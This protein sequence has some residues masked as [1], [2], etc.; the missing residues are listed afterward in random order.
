MRA[1]AI[2]PAYNEAGNI[3]R[4]LEELRREVPGW[5]VCVVDD[6]STDGTGSIAREQGA[7]VLRL[8]FNLGIG[9]AVQTGYLFARQHGYDVAAQIDADGQ[10]D[11]RFLAGA[12][13]IVSSG[14]ADFVVGSRY[15]EAGGFR[16]TVVRRAGS[17]YLSWFL[18]VRCGARVTD[19]TSGF[20]VAGRRAIALFAANYPSDYPEPE[21]IALAIRAGLAVREI[22]VAMRTRQHGRSSI[23]AGRTL[24]Y[25]IK[26]SL[27]LLLLPAD[28]R[29][30]AEITG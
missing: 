4:V 5:D 25:L 20:R 9:G 17:R 8:P 12:L 30:H 2:V 22:P 27:A 3:R 14:G 6:G 13:E 28:R 24:Y 21:A 29:R 18:R 19:P 10:H 11:P 1:L 7:L 26:V 23:G 16:S 15:L